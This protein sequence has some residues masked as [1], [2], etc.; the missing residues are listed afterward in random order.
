MQEYMLSK[1]PQ[2]ETFLQ[3]KAVQSPSTSRRSTDFC[4]QH[5]EIKKRLEKSKERAVSLE[6]Q[7]N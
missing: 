1:H 3:P 6:M 5:R 4:Q 7:T 2:A